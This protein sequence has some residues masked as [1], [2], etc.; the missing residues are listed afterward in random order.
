MT[1]R[2]NESSSRWQSLRIRFLKIDRSSCLLESQLAQGR[3]CS[4]TGVHQVAMLIQ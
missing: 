1:V 3:V 4:V 2:S